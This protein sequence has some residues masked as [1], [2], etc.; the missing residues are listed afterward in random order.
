MVG[1][2]E[3]KEKACQCC[4]LIATEKGAKIFVKNLVKVNLVRRSKRRKKDS[5]VR[6]L[7]VPA[8]AERNSTFL[9]D[10]QCSLKDPAVLVYDCRCHWDTV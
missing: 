1:L 10:I 4:I 7:G 6:L 2:V 5:L 8:V 9:L 3:G